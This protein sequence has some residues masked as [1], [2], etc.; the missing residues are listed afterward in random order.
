MKVLF[1]ALNR[2][3]FMLKNYGTRDSKRYLER[4]KILACLYNE[5]EIDDKQR[6]YKSLVFKNGY[7][8]YSFKVE[9]NS[10]YDLF[11]ECFV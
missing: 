4:F 9:I 10:N 8:T 6:F 7:F 2:L 11:P 5:D 3:T 1:Y